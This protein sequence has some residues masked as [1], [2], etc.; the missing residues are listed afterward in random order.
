MSER[1]LRTCILM[2]NVGV[3]IL[4]FDNEIIQHIF[5]R[6]LTNT[7]QLSELSM[8]DLNHLTRI[9]S[10]SKNEDNELI[11]KVGLVLLEELKNRLDLVAQRGSYMNF[12]SIVRNLTTIDVYDLE[13]MDNI[14]DMDYIKFIYRRNKRLDMQLYE[15]DGY[16]RINLK[17]IYKGNH[18]SDSYLEKSCIL[19]NWIPD[20]SKK[21]RKKSE[22]S[23]AIEDVVQK[24]FTNFQYAHAVAH[25]MNA[26]K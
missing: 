15:I 13:L 12:I 5:D 14:F 11:K 25:R 6:C 21:N 22:F 18:L 20:R 26:G 17:N 8:S 2:A 9:L 7:E 4:L 24:N 10:Y 19:I 23:F 3:P 16:N 1:S